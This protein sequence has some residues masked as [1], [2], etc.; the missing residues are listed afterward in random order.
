[1]D[2]AFPSVCFSGCIVLIPKPEDTLMDNN[3]SPISL[4]SHTCIILKEWYLTASFQIWKACMLSQIPN[5]DSA[6]QPDGGSLLWLD[7]DTQ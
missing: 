1:M 5:L 7:H 3:Q 6:K 4:T 2:N